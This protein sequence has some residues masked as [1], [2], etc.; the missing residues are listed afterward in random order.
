MILLDFIVRLF[1]HTRPASEDDLPPELA[2]LVLEASDR[3]V[4]TAACKASLG[5]EL[6][7]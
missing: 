4:A 2:A 1:S 3:V 5:R 6:S 7:L